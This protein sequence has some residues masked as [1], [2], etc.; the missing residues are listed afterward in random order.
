MNLLTHPTIVHIRHSTREAICRRNHSGPPG[1][2]CAVARPHPFVPGHP[3]GP[4]ADRPGPAVRVGPS[5]A[6]SGPRP[7]GSPAPP[8]TRPCSERK[9]NPKSA[10]LAS[11]ASRGAPPGPARTRRT[12][13]GITLSSG[14]GSG[15]GGGDAGDRVRRSTGLWLRAAHR[16]ARHRA[17]P[18]NGAGAPQRRR[19]AGDARAG[20]RAAR[21]AGAQPGRVAGLE[22]PHG[23]AHPGG[24]DG[25]GV[26]AQQPGRRADRGGRPQA[27]TR[28]RR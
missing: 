5:Q 21:C 9:R 15:D 24:H 12:F 8:L 1:G 26:A 17:H 2:T 13:V 19:R 10:R 25:A 14:P 4:P 3:A 27:D 23:A 28:R 11:A 20:G 16:A 7:H 6:A 22:R 18:G